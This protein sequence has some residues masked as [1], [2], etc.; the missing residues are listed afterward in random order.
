MYKILIIEDDRTIRE[1]L[2]SVLL[3]NGYE[4]YIT[5][6]FTSVLENVKSYTPHL[7]LLDINLPY[8]NGFTLCTQI[9]LFS[10]V[11]IIFVTSRDTDMDELNSITLGGDDFIRKPYNISILL[12]RIG[13]II[14]RSYLTD[15]VWEVPRHK[16]VTLLIE[17]SKIEYKG[18]YAE[19]TKNELK[20]LLL[21]FKNKGKVVSRM[22]IIDY[23]WDNELFVDDNT[24]SV[25]ITRIRSKLE[26]IGVQNFIITKY[27]QG[28]MI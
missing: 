19:I 1:E 14:K 11:P 8:Q 18:K 7:I 20:I 13:A 16:G 4:V 27:K 15:E 6:D 26:Q 24:L 23:L 28:Y 2:T 9:R 21:L 12:A 5:T 3:N 25:N 10:T 22:D 17:G